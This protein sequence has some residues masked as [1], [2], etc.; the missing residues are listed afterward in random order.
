MISTVD[1]R[2][3]V[4]EKDSLFG[5]SFSLQ[6]IQKKIRPFAGLLTKTEIEI[7]IICFC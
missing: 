2:V 7:T 3:G 1:Q 6:E 5:H 4:E